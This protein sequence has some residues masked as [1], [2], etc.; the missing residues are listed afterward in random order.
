ISALEGPATFHDFHAVISISLG[1]LNLLPI[2]IL[3]G[4]QVVYQ[5]A[6]GVRGRPLPE[7][8]QVLG[9]QVGLVLLILLM[10]LAFYNDLA[11]RFG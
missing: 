1:V 6:E 8:V 11:W 9:Q 2:P 5:L 7:R 10:S 4:G 3:D